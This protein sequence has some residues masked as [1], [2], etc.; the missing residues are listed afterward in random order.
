MNPDVSPGD[1]V[2]VSDG[3]VTVTG[4]TATTVSYHH[5]GL[6]SDYTISADSFASYM[7]SPSG[8]DSPSHASA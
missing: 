2:D 6:D 3:T 7:V 1:S 8:S 4:V 5:S